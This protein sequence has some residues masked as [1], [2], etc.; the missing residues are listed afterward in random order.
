MHWVLVWCIVA[1]LAGLACVVLPPYLLP[2]AKGP[3]YGHPQILW[4][5]IAFANFRVLPTMSLLFVLGMAL[6]AAQPRGWLL[7]SCLAGSL[8]PVLNAINII[9]DWTFDPTDHNLFPFEFAILAF[10]SLPA[11]LGA[12]LGSKIGRVSDSQ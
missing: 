1:A 11:L 6:G 9:H 12:F 2:G 10:V 7:L 3:A 5:A 4:F 8:P